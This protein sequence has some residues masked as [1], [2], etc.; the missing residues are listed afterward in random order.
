MTAEHYGLFS[1]CYVA[2]ISGSVAYNLSVPRVV[3]TF[4]FLIHKM[5][6][7]NALVKMIFVVNQLPSLQPYNTSICFDSW[8]LLFFK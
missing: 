8:L 2:L 4:L 5:T 1:T 3:T 6:T 7:I